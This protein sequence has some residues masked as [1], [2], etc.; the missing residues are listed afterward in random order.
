MTTIWPDADWMIVRQESGSEIDPD[1]GWTTIGGRTDDAGGVITIPAGFGLDATRTAIVHE[2]GHA[3]I[4][5]FKR[6]S[7]DGGKDGNIGTDHTPF[8]IKGIMQALRTPPV[9]RFAT[10]EVEILQGY[11]RNYPKGP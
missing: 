2:I 11:D 7:F 3:T 8:S 5:S 9:P 1:D 10:R 4:R 6:I